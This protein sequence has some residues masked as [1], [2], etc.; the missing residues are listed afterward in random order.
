MPFY[1]VEAAPQ[2]MPQGGTREERIN[3]MKARL[4]A[5]ETVVADFAQTHQAKLAILDGAWINT[6][7]K[8]ETDEATAQKLA[9][10]TGLKVDES[11]TLRP[12]CGNEL[13]DRKPRRPGPSP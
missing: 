6:T 12:E 1:I 8:I 9:S 5:L 11:R 2:P 3:E 4:A 13:L 7:L 10:V